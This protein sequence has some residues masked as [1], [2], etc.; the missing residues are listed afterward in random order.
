MPQDLRSANLEYAIINEGYLGEIDFSQICENSQN[1][2][3]YRLDG[4]QFVIKWE[5]GHLP[6]F[7]E[8]GSVKPFVTMNHEQTL[9][10]MA[11]SAW[12]PPEEDIE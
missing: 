8:D 12:S 4:S 6:S 1:T 3:R 10:L 9:E 11:T 2:L 7:I 5:I